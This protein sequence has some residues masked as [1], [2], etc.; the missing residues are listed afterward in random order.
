MRFRMEMVHM[1]G[2]TCCLLVN[3]HTCATRRITYG[4][5]RRHLQSHFDIAQ[6]P[7]RWHSMNFGWFNEGSRA[8]P[9]SPLLE[10]LDSLGGGR[11]CDSDGLLCERL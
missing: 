5:F 9:P 7:G 11:L 6:K 4:G 2:D 10:S 8:D 1:S 3:P